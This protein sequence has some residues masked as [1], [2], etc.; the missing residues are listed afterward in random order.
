MYRCPPEGGGVRSSSRLTEM[1]PT[2]VVD[3][4]ELLLS[5]RW[6]RW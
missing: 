2:V 1:L 6:W 5:S 3:V 4:I